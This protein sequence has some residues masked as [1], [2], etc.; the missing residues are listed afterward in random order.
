[1][2]RV[3]HLY[4]VVFEWWIV[5]VGERSLDQVCDSLHAPLPHADMWVLTHIQQ[6]VG[7][8]PPQDLHAPQIHHT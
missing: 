3:H 4:L 7:H 5:L 2:L 8:R 1:M 6:V